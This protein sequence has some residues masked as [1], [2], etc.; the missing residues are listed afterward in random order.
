MDE[1]LWVCPWGLCNE[2]DAQHCRE[3]RYPKGCGTLFAPGT[4]LEQAKAQIAPKTAQPAQPVWE[5]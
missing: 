4:T 2:R 3:Q 5:R 1:P